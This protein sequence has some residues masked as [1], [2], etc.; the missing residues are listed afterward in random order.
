MSL[1]VEN[2]YWYEKRF[3]RKIRTTKILMQERKT[4]IFLVEYSSTSAVFSTEIL[5]EAIEQVVAEK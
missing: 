3:F 1:N 4:M 2:Y 5:M